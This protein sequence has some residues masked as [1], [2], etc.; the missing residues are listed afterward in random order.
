M[1]VLPS[2]LAATLS[3]LAVNVTQAQDARLHGAFANAGQADKAIKDAIERSVSDFNFV[4][5]PIARSRLRKTNPVIKRLA[6][7]QKDGTIS[8]V[9][10]GAKPY[11]V[12]PGQPPTQ[13]KRDDGELFNVSM[14]WQG[15]MLS[16]TF[17]AEDGTRVS[18]YT[19]SPDGATLTLEV[20]VASPQLKTPLRYQL[21]FK[22]E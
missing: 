13:W 2:L 20:T 9:A 16:N 8:I 15:H 6:I 22:R 21:M 7:T 5:R 1:N 17:A 18:R 14:T 11:T 12:T 10:D 3:A 19:L 4:T